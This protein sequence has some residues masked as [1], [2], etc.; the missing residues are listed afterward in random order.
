MDIRYRKSA[1]KVL[2]RM[3]RP[4]A[5]RIIEAVKSISNR[6]GHL[7][8]IRKLRGR[9][10]FRLRIGG[11]RVIFSLYDHVLDLRRISPRGD[12]YK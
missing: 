6:D 4:Q 1:L 9:D 7:Y 3:P 5:Q 8:D 11:Y 12:A 2:R 10:G